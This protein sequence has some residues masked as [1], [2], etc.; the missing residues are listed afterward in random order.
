MIKI[1]RHGNKTAITNPANGKVQEMINVIFQESGRS[2]ANAKMSS[3]SDFLDSLVGTKT[4][5]EQVRTH[6][7]PVLASEIDKYPVGGE[8][9]GYINRTMFS[10]PQIGQQE[11]TKSRLIDGR[12][13]YFTTYISGAPEA[14]IDERFSNETLLKVDPNA[15]GKVNTRAATVNV[16]ERVNFANLQVPVATGV[17]ENA[18][19]VNELAGAGVGEGLEHA[20]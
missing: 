16:L 13:T 7:H 18:G 17:E 14:D 11:G 6:T 8:L 10:I 9:N 3:T 1:A 12:P 19:K 2:G 4:G 20:E 15:F 5:L